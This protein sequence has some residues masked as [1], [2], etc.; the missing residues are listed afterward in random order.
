MQ[1]A[2]SGAYVQGQQMDKIRSHEHIDQAQPRIPQ[3]RHADSTCITF[4]RVLQASLSGSHTRALS[5]KSQKCNSSRNAKADFS[6]D[7]D[8]GFAFVLAGA[9]YLVPTISLF[10]AMAGPC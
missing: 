6:K 5:R 3:F 9:C 1:R 7:L 4:N 8:A 2:P 10:P